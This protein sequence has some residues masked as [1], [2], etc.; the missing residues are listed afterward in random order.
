LGNPKVGHLNVYAH[1]LIQPPYIVHG[2]I[3]LAV[4]LQ[5]LNDSVTASSH[6]SAIGPQIVVTVAAYIFLQLANFLVFHF[7]LMTSQFVLDVTTLFLSPIC[8]V[9]W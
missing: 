7:I 8:G 2:N 5:S 1:Q 4:K 6:P 9:L 3:P